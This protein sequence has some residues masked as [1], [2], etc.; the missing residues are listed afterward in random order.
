MLFLLFMLLLG[1]I[2]EENSTGRLSFRYK[3]GYGY[4]FIKGISAIYRYSSYV[5]VLEQGT[6]SKQ[7]PL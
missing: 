5:R 3:K 2:Y 1:V 4:K 7:S 6:E